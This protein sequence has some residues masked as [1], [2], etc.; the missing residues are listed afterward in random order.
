MLKCEQ[1][2]LFMHA[3]IFNNFIKKRIGVIS[4]NIV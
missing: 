2:F 4:Q 1:I 3:T